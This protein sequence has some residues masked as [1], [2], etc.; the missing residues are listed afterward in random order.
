MRFYRSVLLILS[1]FLC[2][3][4]QAQQT[5]EEDDSTGIDTVTSQKITTLE[6]PAPG[7]KGRV[8]IQADERLTKMSGFMGRPVD[9]E[10]SVRLKGFRVQLFFD[11][12]KDLVNQR[13]ADFMAKYPKTPLYVDYLAPNFRLRAGDFRTRLQAEE[14]QFEIREMFPDAIVVEEWIELPVL[15]TE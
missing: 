5:A 4:A 13:K 1:G 6:L 3:T 8:E 7:Q 11:N 2:L 9:E 15:R 10:L 12:D 14:L